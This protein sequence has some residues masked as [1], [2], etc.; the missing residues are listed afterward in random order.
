MISTNRFPSTLVFSAIA[1]ALLALWLMG[2][3]VTPAQ[4][5]LP[6]NPIQNAIDNATDG[7]TISIP[8][9]TFTESITVTKNLTLTGVLS[10]TTI[11]QAVTGQRVI[12]VTA[13][14]NLR[15]ENLTVTG[16]QAGIGNDG[17]GIYV[18][19]GNL[20]VVNS[21]ITNN[22]AQYG[23]GIYEG[24]HW[25]GGGTPK[26]V[27]VID[28]ILE[29]NFASAQGGAVYA[30][31][32]AALTNT[33]VL[34]NTANLHGGG[35][36]ILDGRG[37]LV[38]G[39]F[40]NNTAAQDGG[41]VNINNSISVT[42]T[43]F[44]S[45]TAGGAGG[46][47]QQWN[48]VGP[49]VSILSAR[50]ERNTSADRGGGMRANAATTISGT[51][52]LSNTVNTTGK[53]PYG[54]GAH[55]SNTLQVIASTFTGNVTSC[56]SYC[57]YQYGGGLSIEGYNTSAVIED[58]LFE[59]GSAFVGAGV[60]RNMYGGN[61]S[62]T[63]RRSTFRD[64]TGV[65]G[66]GI[67]AEDAQVENSDFLRNSVDRRGAA[68][69][70]LTAVLTATRFISNT[71]A[72]LPGDGGGAV[73]IGSRVDGTN[74]LFAEN[75]GAGDGT[76]ADLYLYFVGG[77]STA[78]TL[79]HVTIAQPSMSASPAIVMSDN[80]L[81]VR[82]SIVVSH[83]V[84]ISQTNST[85]D[86]DYTLFYGGIAT[87]SSGGT[88]TLG[89]HNLTGQNPL[90]VNPTA[91]DYHLTSTSPAVDYGTDLGVTT[92]LD[93]HTRPFGANPDLGAYEYAPAPPPPPPEPKM[94]LPF[95]QKN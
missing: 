94:Y 92:D 13:G 30:S 1:S 45:N 82:N 93:G 20:T 44:I 4:G 77:S 79:R 36:T 22:S 64:N 83:T 89:T 33:Q 80:L 32:S 75:E 28:S 21:R 62:V 91:A 35:V 25:H 61:A 58:S 11:I 88:M 51:L 56:S 87:Q 49:S 15:I 84:G 26:R 16:G 54:G 69:D 73:A 43:Q 24:S 38:G 78:S 71:A 12:T 55:I 85:V 40:R 23:G 57:P 53:D 68:M 14:H 6:P 95:L 19:N 63:V 65:Y 27:D 86:V 37:D 66:A 52:F 5:A 18:E 3:A 76:A 31:G 17:G 41:G 60:S 50:F 42:G 70:V 47:L 7:A 9:A 59:K 81:N 72:G 34:S 67:V 46:G 90:F 74:L 39:I 10:S 8:A 2:V 29:L 48:T